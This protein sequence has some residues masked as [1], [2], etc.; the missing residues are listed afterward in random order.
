MLVQ[1]FRL[2]SRPDTDLKQTS[3]KYSVLVTLVVTLVFSGILALV[4]KITQKK[5]D[6]LFDDD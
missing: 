3:F 2:L 4:D 6:F 5:L 1:S